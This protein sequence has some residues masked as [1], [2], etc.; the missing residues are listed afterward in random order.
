MKGQIG[1]R[2]FIKT[3]ALTGAMILGSQFKSSSV[4]AKKPGALRVPIPDEPLTKEDYLA[5]KAEA[6]KTFEAN[7]A[8][9]NGY[10]FHMPSKGTYPSLFAWDS[11]WHTIGMNR[12]DPKIAASEVEF[13]MLQQRPDGRVPHEV[14][15]PEL[16]P[17]QDIYHKLG[18]RL[19][20]DQFQ[21]TVS[22]Q[23]DPPSFIISAEKIF[24]NTQDRAWLERL[25]PRFENA[26]QYLTKTR[27]FFKTGLPCIVHPWESGTD[28]SPAYDEIIKLDYS[29][30]LGGPQ[31]MLLYPAMFTR[32]KKLGY[33]L[34]K[35]AEANEFIVEDMNMIA[36][37]IRAVIALSRMFEKVGDKQKAEHYR[38]QAKQMTETIQKIHWDDSKG[39]F[40]SRYDLKS[41]KFAKR[42]TCASLLPIMSEYLPK[43]KAERIVKEHITNPEEFWLDYLISFNAKCELDRE[44]IYWEDRLLW[45]GYCIWTNMNWMVCEGLLTHGYKD[46]ARELTRR[47]AKMIRD[48]GF[49]E[50]Y[51][52]RTGQGKNAHPFNWP[53]VVLDMIHLTWPEVVQA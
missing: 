2:R 44:K 15:F 19:S 33:D 16:Q 24:N 25:L 21:G 30:P 22:V 23:V 49:W 45:R 6:G 51:D 11:G 10:I 42:T 52:C 31:R 20:R 36:I 47:T 8:E 46:I 50:F 27:D 35:I 18:N 13:L 53:G 41:P 34:E 26:I 32:Q 37:T 12:I 5:L 48:Q 4:F 28:S 40:W 29:N 14:Q 43:D 17:K 38:N 7:R 1:R 9:L 39:L 3:S